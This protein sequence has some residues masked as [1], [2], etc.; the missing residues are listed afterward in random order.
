MNTFW[1]QFAA[2]FTE[3]R[4][5]K[6]YAVTIAVTAVL[7]GAG[8]LAPAHAEPILVVV[9]GVLAA[10]AAAV[11]LSN[12]TWAGRARWYTSVGRAALYAG[13][14]S[15]GALLVAFGILSP[16]QVDEALQVV[17]GVLTIIGSVLGVIYLKP[18][19]V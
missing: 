6:I 10:I 7:T 19:T 9:Q 4:R 1:E 15:V 11:Q 17:A 13:A 14:G 8:T 12:L 5:S 2:W 3:D 18:D 16:D